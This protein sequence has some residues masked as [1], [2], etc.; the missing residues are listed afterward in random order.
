VAT[1]GLIYLFQ[2]P[3]SARTTGGHAAAVRRFVPGIY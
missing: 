1:R 3:R 2:P